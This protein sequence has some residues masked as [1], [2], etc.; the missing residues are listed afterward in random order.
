M[1]LIGYNLFGFCDVACY[2]NT[3]PQTGRGTVGLKP[4]RGCLR[5]GKLANAASHPQTLNNQQGGRRVNN[6]RLYGHGA[7]VT[8]A[9]VQGRAAVGFLS[10]FGQSSGHF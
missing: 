5:L 4:G 2:V 1:I 6:D 8:P 7:R 10:P 3:E 9:P